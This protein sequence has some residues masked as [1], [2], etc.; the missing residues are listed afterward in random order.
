MNHLCLVQ[1]L[2]DLVTLMLAHHCIKD[3]RNS[4]YASEEMCE[5]AMTC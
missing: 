3:I 5:G 1:S 4:A 2:C